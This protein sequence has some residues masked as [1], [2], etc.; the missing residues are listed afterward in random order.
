VI[1]SSQWAA[2]STIWQAK[3]H[4]LNTLPHLLALLIFSL[5]LQTLES[6]EPPLLH[7]LPLEN[8]WILVE[9]TFLKPEVTITIPGAQDTVFVP[10]KE[11]SDYPGI[12]AFSQD[13]FDK[14][15]ISKD[16]FY[17]R[18]AV[19]AGRVLDSIEPKIVKDENDKVKYAA[20]HLTRP[21][22]SGLVIAPN[23]QQKF[24]NLFGENILVIIPERHTLFVFPD[25]Q[26]LYSAY[27]LPMAARFEDAV[28]ACSR[29]LFLWKKG[30]KKPVV[31][32]RF[33]R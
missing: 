21:I 4:S 16:S 27:L 13:Q 28:Y 15:R 9:P 23:F 10:A 11:I 2:T 33:D 19:A 22:A 7:N 31:I 5:S 24:K 1:T 17:H 32:G 29:E 18:A 30:A 25:N 8:F 12:Q 20:I 3:R 6:K 14:L 26:D